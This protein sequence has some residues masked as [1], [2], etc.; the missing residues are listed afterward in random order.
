MDKLR[1]LLI[2]LA[3]HTSIPAAVDDDGRDVS[4]HYPAV[5]WVTGAAAAATFAIVSIALPDIVFAP[6]AAA[7]ASLAI[8]LAFTG[9]RH[10]EQLRAFAASTA[11]ARSGDAAQTFAAALLTLVLLAK[12]AL[13]ALLASRSPAVVLVVLLC[14]Q[15]LSRLWPLVLQQQAVTGPKDLHL[16]FSNRRG[17]AVALLWT[18]PTLPLAL[19]IH[20]FFW[21][22]LGLLASGLAL[23]FVR[24]LVG[25]EA[26]DA[27]GAAGTAQQLCELAFYFGAAIGLAVR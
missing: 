16:P 12:A 23:L 20:G 11:M 8:A 22:L 24:K 2:A 10:E 25:A 26:A 18:L 14:A 21:Y 1:P 3:R 13:L 4:A 19:L 27:R 7:A 5:G 9:A 6:L 15:V 17:W